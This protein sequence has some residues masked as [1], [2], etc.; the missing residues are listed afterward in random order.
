MPETQTPTAQTEAAPAT[1]VQT[2]EFEQVQDVPVKPAEDNLNIL[3][4]IS[5]PI[6]V[7]LGKTEIPFKRLLQL[8][9]GSVLELNKIVGEPAELFVQD[10]KF[11]TGDIVV[12]N[13]SFAIRIREI[14]GADA[15]N[16]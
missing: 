15:D 9:P 7:T 8:G 5:M 16:A 2:A 10:I 4:D 12:V 13:E 3:L 6:T 1:E 11:A 14:L